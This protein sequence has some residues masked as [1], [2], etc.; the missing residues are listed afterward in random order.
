MPDHHRHDG[1]IWALILSLIINLLFVFALLVQHDGAKSLRLQPFVVS[2]AINQQMRG[3][4]H[5]VSIGPPPHSAA[6]KKKKTIEPPTSLPPLHSNTQPALPT[7]DSHVQ[8]PI[9]PESGAE[10][11]GEETNL[12]P[13][14]TVGESVDTTLTEEFSGGLSIFG[15]KTAGDN[16]TAPEYLAGEKTPYPKQAERNG[17]T[18][19]VLL[20]LSINADGEVEKVGIAKSSGHRVLDQQA[21]QSVSAWRFKPATRNGKAIATTVQQ[22]I[23]FRSPPPEKL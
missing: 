21:R 4:E 16:Y 20:N 11:A 13:L 8:A 19:T 10:I 5:T 14:T 6:G 15:D 9:P 1:F 22:P 3:S 18:G 2:I 12:S 7:P 23:V 17:W